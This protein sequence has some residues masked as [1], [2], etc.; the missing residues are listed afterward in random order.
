MTP[1]SKVSCDQHVFYYQMIK[2]ASGGPNRRHHHKYTG[3]R[4]TLNSRFPTRNWGLRV[5]AV[6]Q[7]VGQQGRR[8]GNQHQE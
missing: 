6:C 1:L 5:P 4:L 3:T 8:G 7:K 2:F